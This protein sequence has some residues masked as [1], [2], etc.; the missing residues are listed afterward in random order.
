[1]RQ[2]VVTVRVS[3]TL[4]TAIAAMLEH[5]ICGVPVVDAAGHLAGILTEGD[6]LRR[7]ELGT[8]TKRPRWLEF[9]ASPGKEA[10]RFVHE[11]G[12]TV[13][14]VMTR[15]VVTVAADAPL[16]QLVKQMEAHR[17]KRVPVVAR[18]RVVGMVTRADLMRV[19]LATLEQPPEPLAGDAAI[20]RSVLATMRKQPWAPRTLVEVDVKDGVVRMSGTIFDE[21]ERDA[22]R[23]IAENTPGVRGYRDELVWVE[24]NSGMV[25]LAP[26]QAVAR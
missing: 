4:G 16:A 10:A 20:R 1:M 25:L 24:P 22:L 19:L 2:N 3:D 23:V 18:G 17:I 9:L 15:N 26:E 7:G 5:G 21:R 12:R 11:Q 14:E 8:E 13:G 6:L